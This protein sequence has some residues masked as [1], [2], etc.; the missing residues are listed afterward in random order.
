MLIF[1]YVSWKKVDVGDQEQER[2]FSLVTKKWKF[3][4]RSLAR[5]SYDTNFLIAL[6]LCI[7]NSSKRWGLSLW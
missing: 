7:C 1:V 5:K 6:Y 4:V 2:V 3:D